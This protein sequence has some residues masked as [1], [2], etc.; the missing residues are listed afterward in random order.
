MKKII[1]ISLFL[2]SVEAFSYSPFWLGIGNT[3]HNFLTAQRDIKGSTKV[4]E[5]G[6]T[7][8]FGMT[9]PFLYSGMFLSPGLGYTKFITKDNTSKSEFI[10]Q[11]HLSQT[12]FSSI[13]LHYGLSNYITRIGG[14]G[15]DVSLNNGNSTSTFY[16]PKTTKTSYTTSLDIAPEYIFNSQFAAKLQVSVLRFLSSDRRRVSHTLTATYFF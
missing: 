15:S 9:I 3:T 7:V 12:L 13:Q 2:F 10:L 16:A 14:D 1:L 6:P 5:F 4:V 11:Y 8:L